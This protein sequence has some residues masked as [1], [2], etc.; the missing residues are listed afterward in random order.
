M[1]KLHF[2]TQDSIARPPS[3]FPL[4]LHVFRNSQQLKHNCRTSQLETSS[5]ELSE[6]EIRQGL[7]GHSAIAIRRCDIFASSPLRH[8]SFDGCST[9]SKDRFYLNSDTPFDPSSNA[10]AS[11]KFHSCASNEATV[12]VL[13]PAHPT[14]HV[15]NTTDE[16]GRNYFALQEGMN[17]K[18]WT[19]DG[20][21]TSL[22]EMEAKDGL[23]GAGFITTCSAVHDFY[24]QANPVGMVAMDG[25]LPKVGT[26]AATSHTHLMEENNV[27]DLPKEEI[28][29]FT[30]LTDPSFPCEGDYLDVSTPFAPEM[31]ST[32]YK[33][34]KLLPCEAVR[35]DQHNL[36]SM[37]GIHED[38]AASLLGGNASVVSPGRSCASIVDEQGTNYD[39]NFM[40]IE[41][42]RC[43]TGLTFNRN[44]FIGARTSK[45]V[46]PLVAYVGTPMVEQPVFP[47][48]PNAGINGAIFNADTDSLSYN[49]RWRRRFKGVSSSWQDLWQ[50]QE[51]TSH[52]HRNQFFSNSN[53]DD[54]IGEVLNV[55]KCLPKN[56]TL[57]EHLQPFSGRID[58]LCGNAILY[59]LQKERLFLSALSFFDWMRLQT[60]CLL[61]SRSLCTIFTTLGH[62]N[63]VDRALVLSDNLK[64]RK[65]LWCAEVFNALLSALSKYSR[66]DEALAVFQ[67]MS[68]MKIQPNSVTFC[69]I[70]NLALKSGSKVEVLWQIFVDLES[71]KVFAGHEVFGVLIKAFCQGGLRDEALKLL[72]MMEGRGLIP[73]SVIYNTLL[74]AFAKAG[75]LEEA[76][77]LV[78]EMKGKGIRL[79]VVT[80]NILID[81][82]A[83]LRNFEVAEGILQG[84]L[85]KGP[86]PNVTSFTAL[87]AAYGRSS[88]SEKAASVFLRMRKIGISPNTV[89]YTALIHAYA[90]DGWHTKAEFAF[91]NM[92][93]EGF[94][95]TVETYTSLLHAFRQAGDLEKVKSIWKRMRLQSNIGTR[96]TFNVL[97]DACA[98]QGDYAEARNVM[99][100]FKK[101]GY[102]SDTKTYNMLINAYSRGGQHSKAPEILEEMHKA[103]CTPDSFTYTT[104][105]FSFL[106]VRDFTLAFEYHDKM[107]RSNQLPDKFTYQKLRALLDE[108]Y[109]IKVERNMKAAIGAQKEEHGDEKGKK[110]TKYFR[111]KKRQP[112]SPS[113]SKGMSNR[114]FWDKSRKA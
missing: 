67:E 11:E 19:G 25:V 5:N 41:E 103:G 74:G 10:M 66:Y 37:H 68:S 78:S 9:F 109:E 24:L 42:L 55:A 18:T 29:D 107:C 61:N 26:C 7:Q 83:S 53:Y 65:E 6:H 80:Y 110:T 15:E 60:P 8:A 88:L 85:D 113:H 48:D 49:Q 46:A 93:R 102:E 50:L 101:A 27:F 76:E 4:F 16:W 77:G 75:M 32:V 44:D 89:A 54:V 58:H 21:F 106:R 40:Q 22:T 69:I 104:L 108:K 87:I 57:Q 112:S 90:E 92:I 47:E 79:T 81:A 36:S 95:P 13:N 71:Q 51:E 96:E 3:Q 43:D 34:G 12:D 111:K 56:T 23:S 82:Y 94:H 62:A 20:G 31:V 99:Y 100:E 17:Q 86:Q 59:K 84:M 35:G 63:M 38:C 114:N 73:N 70:L 45:E 91:E 30:S 28:T 14:R 98:K 33:A 52:E 105:I 2:Q 64:H 39:T 97:M 72:S 1:E